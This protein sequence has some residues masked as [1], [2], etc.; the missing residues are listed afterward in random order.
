MLYY[1]K[2]GIG[3]LI[4]EIPSIKAIKSIGYKVD[5]LIEATSD[6]GR[7]MMYNLPFLDGKF[8]SIPSDV[9]GYEHFCSTFGNSPFQE[10]TVFRSWDKKKPEKERYMAIARQL[11]YTGATQTTGI[12]Y[13]ESAWGIPQNSVVFAPGTVTKSWGGKGWPYFDKLA[14]FFRNVY[15]VGAKSDFLPPFDWPD[16]TVNLIGKISF[17]ETISLIA[18]C[19]LFIG[20]EGGLAHIAAVLKIPTFI[21][22]GP[23][24]IVKNLERGAIAVTKNPLE[25]CQPCQF[26]SKFLKCKH[27]R[28]LNGLLPE[29]VMDE[30]A[31]FDGRLHYA[32]T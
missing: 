7:E 4:Q 14:T 27:R 1:L 25:K 12:F 13:D 5:G 32:V 26:T 16:N 19:K 8:D 23:T 21:L 9:S 29:M 30:I 10:K 6:A 22:F 2:E 17:Q 31:L 15:L 24:S 28:C 3:N 11:E 20:N 18:Q